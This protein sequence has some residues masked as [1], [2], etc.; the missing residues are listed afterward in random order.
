MSL[1]SIVIVGYLGLG[2]FIGFVNCALRTHLYRSHPSSRL[3]PPD[4]AVCDFL[5]RSML[6]WP[7]LVARALRGALTD[8]KTDQ[9]KQR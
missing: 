8:R 7:W 2:L 9:Q 4:N 5:F 6:F 3:V 1:A